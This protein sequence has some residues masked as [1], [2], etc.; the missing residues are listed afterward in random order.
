MLKKLIAVF[1]LA[2]ALAFPALAQQPGG[3]MSP[4]ERA[5]QSMLFAT[6]NREAVATAEVIR[7][8]DQEKGLQEQIKTLT[9]ENAQLKKNP[10]SPPAPPTTEEK[11][12]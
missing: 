1:I 12:E 4:E 5:L 6:T 11:K 2:T 3:Q 9:A 10:A 8:R 7:L